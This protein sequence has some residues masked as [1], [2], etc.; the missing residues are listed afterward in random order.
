MFVQIDNN[1]YIYYR[2]PLRLW[3]AV[4]PKLNKM[5]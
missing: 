4:L 2:E 1:K 5:H 3:L